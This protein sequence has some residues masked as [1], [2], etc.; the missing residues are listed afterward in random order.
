MTEAGRRNPIVACTREAGTPSRNQAILVS[1][2]P[3]TEI[4]ALP[5]RFGAVVICADAAGENARHEVDALAGKLMPGALVLVL[6]LPDEAGEAAPCSP[7]ELELTERIETAVLFH[8]RPQHA[9][10]D[11]RASR[12][13]PSRIQT[14]RR[15]RLAE[16]QL[17]RDGKLKVSGEGGESQTGD[18]ETVGTRL[19]ESE[20]ELAAVAGEL[21]RTRAR[22]D[23][24]A[25]DV[26]VTIVI[27][28]HNAYDELT[29]CVDSVLVHTPEPHKL[30]L[31]D[32]AST[33]DRIAPLLAAYAARSPRV[34]VLRNRA[35]RG[36]TATINLGCA[37]AAGDVVLLN[38]D[39]E[40]AGGW[41]EG[42]QAV[43]RSRRDAGTVTPVSNA[44][45]AFSVPQANVNSELPEGIGIA[46][47]AA[48]V[49]RLSPRLRP[50]APTANG[51]C[52]YIRRELLD[53]VG[54]FDE[55]T[56]PRGYGEENDLS[57]RAES[58]GFVNLID[59]ATFVYHQRSAS[60]GE[61][62][63]ELIEAAK[64][65]LRAKH[66][67][68]KP[69][70]TRFLAED[71][72]C[73]LRS[74]LAD[75][76]R[77]GPEP[78]R[79]LLRSRPT[80][81]LVL[82]AG[83]GGTPETNRDLARAVSASF[84]CLTL[85]CDRDH[86]V[87]YELRGG[88]DVELERCT[89][90]CEWVLTEALDDQRA[91]TFR[92]ICEREKVALVHVRSFIATGPELV[93]VVKGLDLP[94]VCS[95]H[96][97]WTVC[98]TIQLLDESERFC[99]GHCTP[100]PGPCRTSKRWVSQ[101][102]PLKHGYV[103]QWRERMA[104]KLSAADAFVTTSQ[105]AKRVLVDHFGF[106]DDGRM[107]VI[108]HGRDAGN[109]R[110]VSVPPGERTRVVAFGVLGIAK[111]IT[112]LRALLERDRQEGPAFEFHFLGPLHGTFDPEP[113]GGVVHGTYERDELPDRLAAIRPSFAVL[114]SIWAE[115]YCH[116]LTEAWMAG[117]PVFAPDI[118]A[119]GERIRRHGG[120]WLL[121]HT[122]PNAFYA[123][124]RRVR[125]QLG[126]W[127]LRR[128]EIARIP[129]RTVDA[130]A[131]NYRS[132]YHELLTPRLPA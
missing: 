71:P 99:S 107:H 65:R 124:M 57:Q 15:N 46:E 70:V 49:A 90:E 96:D 80:I 62:K 109:F 113:L 127:H 43:A 12:R 108:E 95:H 44:A 37:W 41:L 16:L 131:A 25:V 129:P 28:V 20:A 111:G 22:T 35:N 56:F 58:A 85:A 38:S 104:Q 17:R 84:R 6:D 125:E 89:F 73:E 33:D 48:L 64:A 29:R 21:A 74:A 100:G 3:A 50:T 36:Y 110:S 47:M 55:E 4:R 52:M 10:R 1:G 98:P 51:F 122:D 14:R 82:H 91:E 5:M 87:L 66:P 102:P 106:M 72:L 31:I 97:Y 105:A 30:L 75:A 13:N 119:V 18:P 9:A 2:T 116:A 92:A 26:P 53:R 79:R 81:L 11:H 130:M 45:G 103:Y 128:A 23:N 86:W 24:P 40:V 120:G 63:P 76:L 126:E 27:A 118:G 94:L 121:D 83:K 39:T 123:S 93:D 115:T 60:F 61:Q 68:Y 7:D 114:G 117:L 32:D 42:L 67:Q 78:V 88:A 34:T 101:L 8:Q 54:G 77:G 59:D 112:L 69:A 19:T 132:I